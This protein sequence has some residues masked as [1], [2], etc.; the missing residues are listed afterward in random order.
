MVQRVGQQGRTEKVVEDGGSLREEGA[1]IQKNS[2]LKIC[3]KYNLC[4]GSTPL[5]V[6]VK[7]CSKQSVQIL[8]KDKVN[9]N[10]ETRAAT[11]TV[12]FVR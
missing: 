9:K 11:S 10:F 6:A 12:Y 4:T 1:N 5:M 2:W 3:I 8:I 7:Y